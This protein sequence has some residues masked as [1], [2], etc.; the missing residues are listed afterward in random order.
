MEALEIDEAGYVRFADRKRQRHKTNPE[1]LW[2]YGTM[3]T[4]WLVVNNDQAAIHHANLRPQLHR[5]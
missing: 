3:A 5:D 4:G 1:A 2:S